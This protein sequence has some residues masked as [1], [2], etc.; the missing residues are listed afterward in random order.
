[1]KHFF[2]QCHKNMLGSQKF[3][4]NKFTRLLYAFLKERIGIS[5]MI[6]K[7]EINALPSM[8]LPAYSANS[9]RLLEITF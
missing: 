1:M 8:A 4:T 2:V 5:E 3:A 9:A 6:D 7:S